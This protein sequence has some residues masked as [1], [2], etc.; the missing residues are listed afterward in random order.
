MI[1]GR[2]DSTLDGKAGNMGPYDGQRRVEALDVHGRETDG[3]DRG[4]RL[5]VWVAAVPHLPPDRLDDRLKSSKPGSRRS[6]DVLDEEKSTSWLQNPIDLA[7]RFRLV[8]DAAQD[9]R[10]DYE[11]HTGVIEWESL[12]RGGDQV[13]RDAKTYPF[14][15]EVPSHV[16]IRFDPKPANLLPRKVA[17]VG[18]SSGA[19][20][21]NCPAHSGKEVQLVLCK[22]VVSLVS[23]PSHEPGEHLLPER[24]GAATQ[25]TISTV[26]VPVVQCP[27][28]TALRPLPP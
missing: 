10:A 11:L 15:P 24:P 14:R 28:Y 13:R 4:G 21:Q 5:P 18:A 26:D 22:V 23:A 7:E 2:R 16:R 8:H 9:E 27:E 6:G 25:L 19:D 12:C 1:S 20:L 17:Q 3:L